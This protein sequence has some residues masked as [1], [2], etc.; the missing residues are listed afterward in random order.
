MTSVIIIQKDPNNSLK[1][2]ITFMAAKSGTI[3]I[4]KM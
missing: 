1:H 4:A 3:T 2:K